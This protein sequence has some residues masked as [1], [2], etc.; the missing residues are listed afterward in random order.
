[1]SGSQE[2]WRGQDGAGSRG[3]RG[4][5]SCGVLAMTTARRSP[6]IEWHSVAVAEWGK[7]RGSLTSFP[8]GAPNMHFCHQAATESCTISQTVMSMQQAVA[9][10][11]TAEMPSWSC[12]HSG[13]SHSETRR[14]HALSVSQREPRL[15]QLTMVVLVGLEDTSRGVPQRNGERGRERE[16]TDKEKEK[17]E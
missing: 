10:H 16:L 7:M 13:L 3:G 14:C 12:A 9:Q 1:M 4:G 17:E 15:Q 8:C 5:F 11:P 6:D 2:G